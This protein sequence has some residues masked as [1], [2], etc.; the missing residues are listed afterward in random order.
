MKSLTDY[1]NQL[2]E[3]HVKRNGAAFSFRG[4]RLHFYWD[5]VFYVVEGGPDLSIWRD[6]A[7]LPR[8]D[9]I[10]VKDALARGVPKDIVTIISTWLKTP[11]SEQN[12]LLRIETAMN[13]IIEKWLSQSAAKQAQISEGDAMRK[14]KITTEVDLEE[15]EGLYNTTDDR[16]SRRAKHQL[17]KNE[18]QSAAD[19]SE[20]TKGENAVY[21]GQEVEVRIPVGPNGTTGIMLEGHLKMV[22]RSDLQ[23][24]EEGFGVMGAMKPLGPLNRIMQLAGLEHSGAVLETEVE[25]TDVEE[26]EDSSE[27]TEEAVEETVELDEVNAAAGTMFNQLLTANTNNPAYKNNPAAAKVATIGQVLAG[28]QGLMTGLPPNLPPATLNHIKMVPGIGA[29][30][31]KAATA[32]TKPNTAMTKPTATSGV[33]VKK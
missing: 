31:I 22:K 29:E 21:E 13:H 24:L 2:S 9:E 27:A 10:Y 25:E 14:L 3:G 1:F 20:F 15:T 19:Y 18:L 6:G 32:M 26:T 12:N 7:P 8:R 17:S 4:L 16:W 23:T 11:Q 5:H 30:L 33:T 28:L